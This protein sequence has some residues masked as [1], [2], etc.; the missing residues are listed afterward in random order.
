MS[1]DKHKKERYWRLANIEIKNASSKL[2]LPSFK[3][4]IVTGKW[5]KTKKRRT[6]TQI[7]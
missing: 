1:K 2:K 6:N 5:F 4:A 3:L 7:L